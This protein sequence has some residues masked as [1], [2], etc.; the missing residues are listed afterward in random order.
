[1]NIRY[2]NYEILPK[3]ALNFLTCLNQMIFLSHKQMKLSCKF[4]FANQKEYWNFLK[5]TNDILKEQMK[6][7][8]FI[9]YKNKIF[10]EKN[11]DKKENNININI[12]YDNNNSIEN[13]IN[14]FNISE[15]YSEKIKNIF[16]DDDLKI[17]INNINIKTINDNDKDIFNLNK[18]FGNLNLPEFL[19][20]FKSKLIFNDSNSNN[21]N[22]NNDNNINYMNNKFNTKNIFFNFDMNKICYFYEK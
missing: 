19:D 7:L 4:S 5:N 10:I 17:N 1:M 20:N 21:L 6:K 9:N 18:D 11:D 13:N 22:N 2:I 12:N 8:D 14:L 16:K 3:P 15:F